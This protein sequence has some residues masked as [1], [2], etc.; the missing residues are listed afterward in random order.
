MGKFRHVKAFAVGKLAYF[1][2][3][4]TENHEMRTGP[5]LFLAC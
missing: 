1:V 5:Y 2:I 3:I 4:G